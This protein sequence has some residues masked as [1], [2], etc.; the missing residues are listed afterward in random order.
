MDQSGNSEKQFAKNEL[1]HEE[2]FLRKVLTK[3]F[4]LCE[5][6]DPFAN[7]ELVKFIYSLSSECRNDMVYER[8]LKKLDD[9]FTSSRGPEQGYHSVGRRRLMI[10]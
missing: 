9:F 1:C 5:K 7:V 6:Y 8:V 3:K 2:N 10:L 4:P